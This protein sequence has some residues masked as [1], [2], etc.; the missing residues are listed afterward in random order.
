[1]RE[2]FGTNPADCIAAIGPRICGGCYEVGPEVISSM[3][4]LG[5][6]DGWRTGEKKIDLGIANRELLLRAGVKESNVTVFAG[7]TACDDGFVSWRRDRTEHE[8]QHNL[9]VIRKCRYS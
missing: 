1:M 9:I 7:C 2:R 5:I 3:D 8:R 4:A 6:G